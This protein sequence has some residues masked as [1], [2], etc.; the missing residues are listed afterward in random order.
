[1]G[2]VSSICMLWF[3]KDHIVIIHGSV[4][5]DPI[6][7]EHPQIGKFTFHPLFNYRFYILL[8]LDIIDKMMFQFPPNHSLMIMFILSNSPNFET[9]HDVSLIGIVPQ[10]MILIGVFRIMD[11][12]H[13]I[14][15][16]LLPHLYLTE[17][18]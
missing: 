8:E 10:E 3:N 14:A 6:Q 16:E 9:G 7:I 17:V 2:V 18:S 1:M 15:L 11:T 13:V 4:L 12:F 5:I